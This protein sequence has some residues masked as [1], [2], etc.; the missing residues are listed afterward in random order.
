MSSTNTEP[1]HKRCKTD[2]TSLTT[3]SCNGSTEVWK[4]ALTRSSLNW[5]N[6]SRLEAF[7]ASI[8]ACRPV[9]SVVDPMSVVNVMSVDDE[10]MVVPLAIDQT[11]KWYMVLLASPVSVTEWLITLLVSSVVVLPYALVVPYITCEFAF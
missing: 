1:E 3:I 8:C 9:V 4:P 7:S 11:W 5:G 6:V 10:V 2:L